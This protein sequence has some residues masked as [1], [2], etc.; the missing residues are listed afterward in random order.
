MN[1]REKDEMA[2]LPDGYETAAEALSRLWTTKRIDVDFFV[3]EDGVIQMN[4]IQNTEDFERYGKDKL[5]QI[6]FNI[7]DK[8]H[9]EAE[10]I[11]VNP[12]TIIRLYFANRTYGM[13]L[14]KFDE[15]MKKEIIENRP[16]LSA[17]V[18]FIRIEALGQPKL[19]TDP[20]T[21]NA[22]II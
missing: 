14:E 21:R 7:L 5:Q 20:V 11:G 17:Y 13:D 3:D 8:I 9:D 18:R 16:P 10:V 19:G 12:Q 6:G 22:K 15:D 2:I 4:I 1:K